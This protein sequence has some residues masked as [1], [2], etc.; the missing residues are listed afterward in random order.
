MFDDETMCEINRRL[1]ALPR[2]VRQERRRQL[3]AR[4]VPNMP[5]AGTASLVKLLAD[6]DKMRA[7]LK[8]AMDDVLGPAATAG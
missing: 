3:F 6:S 2:S 4:A 7:R 1:F 8:R 5:V